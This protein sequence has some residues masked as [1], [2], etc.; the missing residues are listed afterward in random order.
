M[1]GT[2]SMQLV[3]FTLQSLIVQI[4]PKTFIYWIETRPILM[5]TVMNPS[6]VYLFPSSVMFQIILFK[7]ILVVSPAK[8]LEMNTTKTKWACLGHLVI[9]VVYIVGHVIIYGHKCYG[10]AFLAVFEGVYQLDIPN[11]TELETL[12]Y[13]VSGGVI[14]FIV[15]FIE[16]GLQLYVAIKKKLKTKASPNLSDPNTCQTPNQNK[17]QTSSYN[18]T[19]I[20]V[21]HIVIKTIVFIM[22]IN[23][24]DVLLKTIF[25]YFLN[26][27]TKFG[28]H[29]LPML[30]ILN[31]EPIK[32]FML[33]KLH[34]LKINSF[35]GYK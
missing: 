14:L 25:N 30:W 13:T 12:P 8:F 19:L 18:Y 21:S 10:L 9:C 31:H 11:L 6:T 28:I 33:H 17:T 20:L 24:N 16:I 23:T 26:I 5:C 34:Q 22:I 2:L 4:F 32:L 29:V 1:I 7:I 35:Y 15:F 3:K 27:L